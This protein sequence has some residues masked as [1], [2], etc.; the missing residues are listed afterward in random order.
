MQ[1]SQVAPDRSAVL[2]RFFDA[3]DRLLYVGITENPVI[4]AG[5]HRL[6]SPWW[7]QAVRMTMERFGTRV[8][9]WEAETRAITDECPLYNRSGITI[10]RANTERKLRVIRPKVVFVVDSASVVPEPPITRL[11]NIPPEALGDRIRR[12]RLAANLTMQELANQ[13]GCHQQT[14][15][16]LEM[17]G[18]NPRL[19]TVYRIAKAFGI[20]SSDL[21][22]GT[23]E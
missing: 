4:R 23:H 8:E 11:T 3:D 16:E 14:I 5:G 22:S 21:V 10:R 18:G 6:S 17:H 7:T 2:Y 20:T 19:W 13:V 15:Y 12:L 9:A 1:D